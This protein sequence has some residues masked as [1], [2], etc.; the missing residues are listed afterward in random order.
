MSMLYIRVISVVFV[1]IVLFSPVAGAVDKHQCDKNLADKYGLNIP[2]PEEDID[3]APEWLRKADMFIS[4]GS[5]WKRYDIDL[6]DVPVKRIVRFRSGYATKKVHE[7]IP[8]VI[9]GNFDGS[10]IKGVSLVSHVPH[11]KAAFKQAHEQGFRAIPYVHF[12]C[13]HTN[14]ADQDVFYFEHPE[15][16]LKDVDGHWVHIYMD[17]TYRLFRLLTC[18][19]SPSYWKLS[20]AYVKKMMD[21]GADG[22]FIDNI[23]REKKDCYAPKFKKRNPE[24]KPY[25]HEHL[26]PDASNNYAWDRFLQ[27]IRSLV[28]SYGNDKIVVLNSGIGTE[29]QKNGDCCMWES[30]IYSWA[31]EGRRHTWEKIKARAKQNQWFLKAGRRITALSYLNRSRKEVKD[32]AYWAFSAARLVD[33]IWWAS[34]NGT[35]AEALYQAHMGKALEPLKELNQVAHRTFENGLIVL[36]D[37]LDDKKLLIPLPPEFRHNWLLDLY[38]GKKTIK[39]HKAQI[40]VTVPSKKARIYI[41]PE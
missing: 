23:G 22:V 36:N 33:F 20:L 5:S 17:G 14:Y 11:S 31:W 1:V 37:S 6:K 41:V 7:Q 9:D 19:N 40:E 30:F 32:D 28:K 35:G 38:D 10:S 2:A 13:I 3:P 8:V 34:L 39:V 16:L 26:F 12:T 29:F 18:P 27:T 25:V 24:F 4:S 15:I 21:W